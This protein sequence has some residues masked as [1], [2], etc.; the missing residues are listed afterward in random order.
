MGIRRYNLAVFITTCVL[1]R[2]GAVRCLHP[3][4]AYCAFTNNAVMTVC[5]SPRM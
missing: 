4:T 3:L 5:W 1:L 2:L